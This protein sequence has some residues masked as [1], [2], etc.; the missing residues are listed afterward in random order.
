MPHV[1]MLGHILQRQRN[2]AIARE[3]HQ[4]IIQRPVQPD[5]IAARLP[6]VARRRR[7]TVHGILHAVVV[8]HVEIDRLGP[9]VQG[10]GWSED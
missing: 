10:E 5:V 1:M 6:V 3:A 7:G 4:S 2:P 8:E 9:A